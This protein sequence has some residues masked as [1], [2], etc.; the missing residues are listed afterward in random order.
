MRHFGDVLFQGAVL[1]EQE[2][3]G[4]REAY[5]KMTAQPAPAG[6]AE[7][8]TSFIASRDSFYLA[9][10]SADGWP[11]VQHRG[12]PEGFLK[13]IDSDTLA[14]GDYRGNKQYVSTGHFAAN[15]RAALFLMD[16]PNKRR[17][18]ILA[19]ATVLDA[20]ENENLADRIS[21]EGE[22]RIERVFTLRVDAF[23]WN[24]PQFI[25][26]RYTENEVGDALAPLHQEIESLQR[27]NALLKEKL[28]A[29][30]S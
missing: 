22:G 11:Y 24:C 26:P 8:E 18:K 2:K 21:T 3:R 10:V 9:S 4:S 27:E 7:R 15:D 17:L 6:L 19:H 5:A 20:A 28:T 23:D 25:T 14:F 1:E 29:L 30:S 13:V 16:Y 12:G